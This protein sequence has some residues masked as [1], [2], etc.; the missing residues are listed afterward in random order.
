ML[1]G[2]EVSGK[3]AV[4]RIWTTLHKGV[5]RIKLVSTVQQSNLLTFFKI[6]IYLFLWYWA[7]N[8]EP[9]PPALFCEGL[10]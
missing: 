9:I 1:Q 8:S 10:F 5:A 3:M 4:Q 7:L 6:F 2:A